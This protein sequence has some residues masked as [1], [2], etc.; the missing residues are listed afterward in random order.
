MQNYNYL[1]KGFIKN[2]VIIIVILVAV[3]FSQK[4]DFRENGKSLLS[5]TA[6]QVS[7]WVKDNAL[8]KISGEVEKR[9]EMIK[10][11]INQE[12]QKISETIGEKI[13]NYFSG[14]I[15]NIFNPGKN[16]NDSQDSAPSQE[17]IQNQPYQ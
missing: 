5:Q 9:G 16:N 10:N 3:F 4:A 11:E 8:P 15:D 17:L 6:G 1:E 12:K 7:G 13:K 14:I 2:I